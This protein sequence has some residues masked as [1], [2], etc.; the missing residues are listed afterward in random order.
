MTELSRR[1]RNLFSGARRSSTKLI[2]WLSLPFLCF[3]AIG[4]SL[5]DGDRQTSAESE[6]AENVSLKKPFMS[7]KRNV[8]MIML[9]SARARSMTPYNQDLET[10]PYLDELS[11]KSL[12]A[13]RA[14]TTIP[15]TTKALVSAEC[16]VPPHL[17]R[18]ITEAEPGGIP[19]ECLADLLKGSGYETAFFQP[20]G[21]GWENRPQLVENFGHEDLIALEQM[22]KQGFEMANYFGYEDAIMYDPIRQWLDEN[23][24]KPFLNTYKTLTPHHPYLAPDRYGIEDFSDRDVLNNYLN[25]LR[26]V[27]FFVKNIIE[28]YKEMGLYEDTIFVIY[29]D[30]GEGFE[31]HGRTQHDNVIWEEG[32]RVPLMIHDP[33]RFQNGKRVDELANLTDILPTV[34][35]LLGYEV[36]GGDYPGYS[37]LDLPGDRTIKSRCWHDDK[38]MASIKDGEKYIYHYK[39]EQP[40]GMKQEQFFDLS[41]DPMEKN[42]L[43]KSHPEELNQR[44]KE[45]FQWLEENDELYSR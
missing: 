7:E 14:Y 40:K 13:E 31:E 2:L 6:Q 45:L 27:D 38:C 41:E 15:H 1:N 23:G 25:S 32:L 24:N 30:H 11:R 35:D 36:T 33:Q 8:V 18:E 22:N 42:N 10:T 43:A 20:G 17:K 21:V 19:T 37:L 34:L 44:K 3:L 29:G 5:L 9:E 12:L 39:G 16:G 4:C 26:Y 28:M